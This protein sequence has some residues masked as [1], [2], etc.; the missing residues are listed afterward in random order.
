MR[1]KRRSVAA[2]CMAAMLLLLAAFAHA[3]QT[4]GVILGRVMDAT[5]AAVPGAQVNLTNERTG[6]SAQTAAGATG[7]FI[8][9]NLDPGSYRLT[10]ENEGFKTSELRGLTLFVSDTVR[11]DVRLDVGDLSTRVEVEAT[12]PVVQSE[13]SS[14]GSVVDGNQMKAMPLNGRGS[15]YGLLALAPGVQNAGS[16]PLIAGGATIGSTNMTVDGVTNNDVGNERLLAPVPSLDGI[17]E[18]K[19]IANGASAEFGRGGAQVVVVTKSGTNELHGSLFAFNRNRAT[20]AK[21]FFATGLPLPAF[22]RNEYGGSLGGPVVRNK[23]FYFGSFEGLR[24]AQSSTTTVAMPTAA[25]KQG[26]FAGLAAIRDPWSGTPFADN[27]IPSSR[28]SQVATELQ[29]FT[30]DPNTPGTGAAGLGNNLVSNI[31][32]MEGLDRYSVRGDYNV[33]DNDRFTA[34]YYHVNNGPFRSPSNGTDKFGNWGGFGIATRNALGSYTRVLSASMINEVRFGFNSEENFREP[35]NSDFDPSTIIPGLISPLEGLGGL[36]T[37]NIT[38]FRGFSDQPGSGDIKHSYEIFDNFTWTRSSHT[39]KAGFEYQRASAFNWQNPPPYRGQFNFTGR[40]AGHP[41]A[42]FLLGSMVTSGRVS[43][44]VESEPVNSRYGVYI[45]DDWNALP[46]LTLNLGMRYEYTPPFVN[47]RGDMSNFYPDLG[48]VVVLSGTPDPRLMSTLPIISGSEAGL[49]RDNYIYKDRNNFGPRIGFAYRPLGS[50]R[51]VVRSSYGIY[52]NVMSAYQGSF[53][54]AVNPPFIV[55]ETFE[56]DAGTVPSLTWANP[57]PGAGTIPAAPSLNSISRTRRTPYHQQ[58][59]FTI[60]HEV[61]PSTAVRI[62]YLGNK[63]THLDRNFNLNDPPPAPGVVQ[64]QRPYQPFGPI[65]YIDSGRD[66]ITH[67]LQLGAQRRYSSGMAFQLEYQFTRALGPSNGAPMDNRN[68]R[69][70]RGN[71]DG[72]RR[73]YAAANYIYDLP[74]GRGKRWLDSLPGAAEK[75]VGGWQLAGILTM[76]S[77]APYSVTFTS[78][79]PGWPSNR[80]DI[81]GDPSVANPSIAQWFNPAAFAVPQPFLFGNSARNMLF[82]PGLFSLNAAVFKNTQL[83]EKLNL[84][85]RAESFNTPNHANFGNPASNISVPA[86][87]GRINSAGEAR[88]IQFG[89]RLAF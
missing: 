63:G 39:I 64:A 35:Q 77:G 7:D 61:L 78:T 59:N 50:S 34:R 49:G 33:S 3:Q 80:A 69:L 13:T 54:L 1:S 57:F 87:V 53:Q 66:S 71:I 17:S 47:S 44:N 30:T 65:S 14:V 23:L 70:D 16:N 22:N 89:M 6:T 67:Q 41:Y 56:A 28:I 74:F 12:T 73:H 76:A 26:N 5:G 21:N 68:S 58:W 29:K 42:D 84:E 86:T 88:T 62:S 20:A 27:L 40:F 48:Q 75:L 9:T 60:E 31:P 51:L 46:K 82:G 15:I 4:R 83:T 10:V 36:P 32:R 11:A 85:F 38:G 45:Q 43:K 52:Y 37:V 2:S 55:A 19:V 72:I 79:T 81:V 25:L 18:F 8:F 24:L